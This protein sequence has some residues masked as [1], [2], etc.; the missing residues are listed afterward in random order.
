MGVLDIKKLVLDNLNH[1]TADELAA[2]SA[3]SQ[4]GSVAYT[5]DP[6]R[7][8]VTVAPA[9]PHTE[10]SRAAAEEAANPSGGGPAP[11]DVPPAGPSN[12]GDPAS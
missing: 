3:D 5:L 10:E 2:A 4:D 7:G 6:A 9:I 12:E 8:I 11:A 1:P